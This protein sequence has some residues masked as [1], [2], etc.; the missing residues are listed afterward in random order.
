MIT[1]NEY[2]ILYRNREAEL[3]KLEKYQTGIK[4]VEC[5]GE[6]IASTDGINMSMPPTKWIVCD[7]CGHTTVMPVFWERSK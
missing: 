7:K 1:L 5:D 3:M 6:Y 2:C 4:C